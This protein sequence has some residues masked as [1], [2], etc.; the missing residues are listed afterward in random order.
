MMKDKNTICPNCEKEFDKDFDFCPHCG[1]RNKKLELQLKY[2]INDFL[3]GTFNL[4]S[5]ILR[6][7]NL[8]IFY[9]GKLSKVFLAGKRASYVPPV[10]LYLIISLVYFTLLSFIGTDISETKNDEKEELQSD[11][12]AIQANES[13]NDSLISEPIDSSDIQQAVLID[14]G[15]DNVVVTLDNLDKLFENEGDSAL[16]KGLEGRAKWK[17]FI[18]T[19]LKKLGTKEG[20]QDFKELLRKYIS[21]GMF[22]LMPITALIFGLLFYRKTYYIQHL[23]FVLHL[24]SLMFIIFIFFNL[25]ALIGDYGFIDLLFRATFLFVL[26]IWIKKFYEI[27]WRKAIWKSFL[28]LIMFGI[29]FGIFFVVVVIVSAWNL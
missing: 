26:I 20:R 25:L 17:K 1:Q 10:R 9:P 22:V 12:T 24:Q 23:V 3:S 14:N 21:I 15:D 28:F 7:L 29:S 4:D 6:T 8:L 27:A 18:N 13:V 19:Q 2:F 16:I 11:T 5:K